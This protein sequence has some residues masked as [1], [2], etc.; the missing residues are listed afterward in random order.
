MW[1][2][3]GGQ[4]VGGERGRGEEEKKRVQLE[5]WWRSGATHAVALEQAVQVVSLAVLVLRQWTL[6]DGVIAISLRAVAA[7]KA[8]LSQC[9]RRPQGGERSR[10]RTRGSGFTLIIII[11]QT[12]RNTLRGG[13]CCCCCCCYCCDYYCCCC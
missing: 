4:K 10:R 8:L 11:I 1:V 9:L 2:E 3:E 12:T 5:K 6:V 7:V 13:W